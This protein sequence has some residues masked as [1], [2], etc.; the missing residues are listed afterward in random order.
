MVDAVHERRPSLE[1][2]PIAIEDDDDDAESD[3]EPAFDRLPDE[4]IEQ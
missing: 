2:K 3:C 1:K 4:I